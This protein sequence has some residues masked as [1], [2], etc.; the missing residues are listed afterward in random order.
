[1]NMRES[2]MKNRVVRKS[3]LFIWHLNIRKLRMNLMQEHRQQST[4]GETT[5]CP[6]TPFESFWN[7]KRWCF[8]QI[9]LNGLKTEEDQNTWKLNDRERSGSF[10]LRL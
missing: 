1:M 2:W 8:L 10:T 6:S 3:S 7:L 4:R 5:Q 9:F